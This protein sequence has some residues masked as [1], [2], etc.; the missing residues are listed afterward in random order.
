MRNATQRIRETGMTVLLV[1]QNV[2]Q[3]LSIGDH[4]YVL[5]RGSITMEGTGPELLAR[6]DLKAAYLGL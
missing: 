1:E 6:E 4:A 5:E 2:Y 3:A